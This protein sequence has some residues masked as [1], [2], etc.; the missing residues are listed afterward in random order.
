MF[1]KAWIFFCLFGFGQTFCPIGVLQNLKDQKHVQDFVDFILNFNRTY[2][3]ESELLERL[4]N[5]RENMQEILKLQKD[6]GTEMFGVNDLVDWSE[7]ELAN[8][9]R[10]PKPPTFENISTIP[11]SATASRR[12]KRQAPTNF[13]WRDS[14]K[15]TPVKQQGCMWAPRPMS[16]LTSTSGVYNPS[17]AECEQ[18]EQQHRGHL[19][20]IVGYGV[21]PNG[22][23]YWTIKNSWGAGWGNG[24]FFK[25]YRGKK[26]CWMGGSLTAA[27]AKSQ[28]MECDDITDE[29]YCKYLKSMGVCGANYEPMKG[30]TGTCGKCPIGGSG[31][32]TKY[33]F[34]TASTTT[35]SPTT[36]TKACKQCAAITLNNF[37]GVAT[38]VNPDRLK[39]DCGSRVEFYCN[40]T[41][42]FKEVCF[43][44]NNIDQNGN[45]GGFTECFPNYSVQ[46][47]TCNNG[48]WT[49]NTNT[50]TSLGCWSTADT[51]PATTP[52][53]PICQ[54]CTA[55]TIK[56]PG[57]AATSVN[58]AQSTYNCGA[59]VSYY[60]NKTT[61][62][63]EVCFN[64]NSADPNG[65]SS[66]F[67]ECFPNYSYQTITCN[68]GKW[69]NNTQTITSLTC[70]QTEECKSCSPLPFTNSNGVPA[71]VTPQQSAYACGATVRIACSRPASIPVGQQKICMNEITFDSNGGLKSG[72]G[73]FANNVWNDLT[74]KDGRW[75][76]ENVA[77]QS[78]S[79]LL[80]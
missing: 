9:A 40:K 56:N 44:V 71:S 36:T 73:C 30:C 49:N 26:T 70:T 3:S 10:L 33:D 69:T 19:V 77:F 76:G 7:S 16:F 74:C 25:L 48:Q 23:P 63:K 15:V 53:A 52:K 32:S 72:L 2:E 5:F 8:L 17:D 18:A 50:I 29:S 51:P 13:D 64:V 6:F 43:R 31:T 38:S 37:G 58:P 60:C 46:A 42:G 67:T 27:S 45:S 35:K 61:G 4:K 66:G 1:I 11:V 47:L 57:N 28:P 39:Y 75:H 68:N 20:T 55:L 12:A 24:G 34:C 65:N 78:I 41:V 80:K 14:N 59:Q 22:I 21:D 62:H 79:C 54:Q